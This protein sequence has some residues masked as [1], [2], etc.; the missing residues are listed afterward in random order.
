[1]ERLYAHRSQSPLRLRGQSPQS[2]PTNP[3]RT[4]WTWCIKVLS[5][6]WLKHSDTPSKT[7][8][9]STG[10]SS[11]IQALH[12]AWHHLQPELPQLIHKRVK[13]SQLPFVL[14]KRKV[15]KQRAKIWSKKWRK[16]QAWWIT[17]SRRSTWIRWATS[18][19]QETLSWRL[20][21]PRHLGERKT[22][23]LPLHLKH[24]QLKRYHQ[25]WIRMHMLKRLRRKLSR[26]KT[27]YAETILSVTRTRLIIKLSRLGRRDTDFPPNLAKLWPTVCI[28]SLMKSSRA[29][30]WKKLLRLCK[31]SRR[32]DA[33]RLKSPQTATWIARTVPGH[34]RLTQKH[35]QPMF[36]V[37]KTISRCCKRRSSQESCRCYLRKVTKVVQLRKAS[38]KLP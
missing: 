33:S 36:I 27:L 38:L 34:K 28:F 15:C 18:L 13:T 14:W 10:P 23:S 11:L 20:A 9:H 16:Q 17:T 3:I 32:K 37:S 5:L 21:C 30:W 35:T 8:V 2:T 29:H 26:L 4:R 31:S 6:V 24:K 7:E 22:Q 25:A 1:M 19:H 12:P